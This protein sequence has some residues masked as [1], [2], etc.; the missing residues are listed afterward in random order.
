MGK[1]NCLN[2]NV[3]LYD[4]MRHVHASNERRM[5]LTTIHD[6]Q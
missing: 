5:R 1:F 2:D 3:Y 4:V 6:K